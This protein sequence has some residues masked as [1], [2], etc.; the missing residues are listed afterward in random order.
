MIYDT[1]LVTFQGSD[2]ETSIIKWNSFKTITRFRQ[3][4]MPNFIRHLKYLSQVD[5]VRV[6][7]TGLLMSFSGHKRRTW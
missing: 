5:G 1:S 3:L 2:T 6:L 7:K 4:K